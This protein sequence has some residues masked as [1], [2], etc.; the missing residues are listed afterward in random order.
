MQSNHKQIIKALAKKIPGVATLYRCLR[1]FQLVHAKPSS[2]PFGFLIIGNKAMRRGEYEAGDIEIFKKLAREADVVVNAGAHVGYYCL[3]ALAL[4]KRVIA[5]EPMPINN[6]VLC[7][8]IFLNNW[9]ARAEVFQLALGKTVGIQ[10]IYGRGTGAS[11]IKGWAGFS[12]RSPILI[13]V[14]T[15]DTVLGDR[16]EGQKTLILADVEGAEFE[17]LEGAGK[18]LHLDPKPIWIVEIALF[19]HQPKGMKLN[20][21]F[22]KTFE[23]FWENGYEAYGKAGS[24]IRLFSKKEMQTDQLNVKHDLPSSNFIF[25][26][27]STDFPS[28]LVVDVTKA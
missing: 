6:T 28:D 12:S 14:S 16:L 15:L 3:H 1:D 20:S 2:T 9:G 18:L 4:G 11:L 27:S 13:P 26:H 8:N 23:L 5:F 21:N 17:L 19:E 7:K 25:I 10:N 24:R 22:L